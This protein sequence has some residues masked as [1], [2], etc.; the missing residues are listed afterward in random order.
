MMDQVVLSFLGA[1]FFRVLE[2]EG[3]DENVNTPG[4]GLSTFVFDYS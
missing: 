3:W 2:W 4:L 1:L